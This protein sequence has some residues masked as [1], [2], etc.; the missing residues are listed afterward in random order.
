VSERAGGHGRLRRDTDGCPDPDNDGDAVADAQDKCPRDP[1]DRDAFEDEDGCPELD[2]DKDGY[3]DAADK[4]P[5]EAGPPGDDGCPPRYTFIK[6]TEERIEIKQT[7]F[8][9]TAKAVIM[10]KS[11]PL[12]DE[13]AAALKSRPT[14]KVRVEGHTDSQ[15]NRLLNVRLSQARADSVKAYLLGHGIAI[16]RLESKGFGPDQPIES[17]KTAAGR[18]K[19]RRVDFVIVER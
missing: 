14:M 4:C 13:V 19:N 8:F 1:E 11:Y 10:R 3:V 15:G 17:N 9:Q 12:L 7:I 6:V 16:D 2:N 18:E 5:N